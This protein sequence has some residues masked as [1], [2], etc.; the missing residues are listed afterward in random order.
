MPS[1]DTELIEIRYEG[2]F[3]FD[4]LYITVIDWAKNYGYWWHEKTYKHKVPNPLGA[5]QQLEWVCEKKVTDYIK[6]NLW[7]YVHVW[8]L[9]EVEVDVDGQKKSLSNAYMSIRMKGT[10]VYDWQGKF[11]EGKF[12]KKLGGWYRGIIFKKEVE[13]VY[14]D[15]IYYRM[16]DLHN[17]LKKFLDMQTKKY[18]YKSYLGEG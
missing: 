2:L 12:F 5:E 4:G 10:V 18:S 7:F 16:W 15:Q 13:S 14:G 8:N 11:S 9:T 6:Y 17:I 3:D 1:F